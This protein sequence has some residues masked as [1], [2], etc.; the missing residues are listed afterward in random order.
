MMICFNRGGDRGVPIQQGAYWECGELNFYKNMRLK[1]LIFK[2]IQKNFK[3]S[4]K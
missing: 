1:S 2:F 4:K 3:M